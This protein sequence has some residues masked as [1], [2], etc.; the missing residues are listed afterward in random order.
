MSRILISS[1]SS[2]RL[3]CCRPQIAKGYFK[4]TFYFKYHTSMRRTSFYRQK[5]WNTP[6]QYEFVTLQVTAIGHHLNNQVVEVST[7]RPSVLD[8]Q[9]KISYPSG[10]PNLDKIQKVF[11]LN[12]KQMKNAHDIFCKQ[13]TVIVSECTKNA[14]GPI[15]YAMPCRPSDA[16]LLPV[17]LW[18]ID[19]YGVWN[20]DWKLMT[21]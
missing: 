12:F 18:T 17:T 2:K 4:M 8:I 5:L 15:S 20:S 19:R 1:Q 13:L 3:L 7:G 11:Q 16:M 10:W 6:W 9:Q 14:T 21:I